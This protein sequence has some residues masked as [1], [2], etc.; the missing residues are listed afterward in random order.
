M[1]LRNR[2]CPAVSQSCRRTVRSSKYIVLLRKS[3]PMV[4]WYDVS[5]L[6]YMNREMTLVLPTD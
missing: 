2:S 5:N 4:A 6:S 3:I 1:R